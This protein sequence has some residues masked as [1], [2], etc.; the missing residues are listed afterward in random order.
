M[1]N[2]YSEHIHHYTELEIK[3]AWVLCKQPIHFLQLW[4]Q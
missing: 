2:L 3:D 4:Q 1:K